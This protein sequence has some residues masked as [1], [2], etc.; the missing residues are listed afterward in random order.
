[1]GH[2]PGSQWWGYY[3]GEMKWNHIPETDSWTHLWSSTI[4]TVMLNDRNGLSTPNNS[5]FVQ[6]LVKANYIENTQLRITV[7]MSSRHQEWGHHT[8][9]RG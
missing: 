9:D 1:M 8:A 7:S 5:Q 3:P 2:V 6:Q 4:A